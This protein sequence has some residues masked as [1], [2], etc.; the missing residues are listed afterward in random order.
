M[1]FQDQVKADMEAAI[2]DGGEEV[3]YTPATGAAFTCSAVVTDPQI[4]QLSQNAV[5]DFRECRVLHSALSGAGL[6]SPTPHRERQPGDTITI[7]GPAGT[8]E[9]WKVVELPRLVRNTYWTLI[10]ERNIRIVP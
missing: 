7:I 3:T 4:D 2:E 5:R 9:V 8:D 6:T 1:S 10:L